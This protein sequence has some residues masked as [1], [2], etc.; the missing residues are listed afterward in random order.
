MNVFNFNW[1][2]FGLHLEDRNFLLS[3]S[4]REQFQNWLKQMQKEWK[5]NLFD[6]VLILMHNVGVHYIVHMFCNK[7]KHRNEICTA[8]KSE[9]CQNHKKNKIFFQGC[10][11]THQFCEKGSNNWITLWNTD[12]LFCQ[13]GKQIFLSEMFAILEMKY[14]SSWVHLVYSNLF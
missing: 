1:K 14:L 10:T 11:R 6:E 7:N 12:L 8:V 4:L 13:K 2:R 9:W 5:K 3:D